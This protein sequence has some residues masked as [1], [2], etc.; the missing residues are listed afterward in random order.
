MI[1]GDIESD[2]NIS[3]PGLSEHDFPCNRSYQKSKC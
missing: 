1:M 3:G 2:F